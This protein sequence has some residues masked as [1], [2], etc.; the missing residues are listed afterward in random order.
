M[1]FRPCQFQI[2]DEEDVSADSMDVTDLGLEEI[3][4]LPETH[5]LCKAVKRK[6]LN[7]IKHVEKKKAIKEEPSDTAATTTT[8]V[9]D[10]LALSGA[11]DGRQPSGGTNVVAQRSIGNVEGAQ[12]PGAS[13]DDAPIS[14][15]DANDVQLTGGAADD[16][17]LP[18]GGRNDVA[19]P[20]A[21]SNV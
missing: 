14:S 3:Q 5:Q 20:P 4:R 21:T 7:K 16:A 10:G 12:L 19:Q 11:D 17:R 6:L 8:L 9:V 2:P 15:G 18:S 13:P 1:K